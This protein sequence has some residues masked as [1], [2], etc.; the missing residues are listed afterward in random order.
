LSV[1]SGSTAAAAGCMR[2][3]PGCPASGSCPARVREHSLRSVS[4]RQATT[5]VI[6]SDR[7]SARRV[8]TSASSKRADSIRVSDPGSCGWQACPER[9]RAPGCSDSGPH[10][11][12][13]TC[14]DRDGWQGRKIADLCG[15]LQLTQIRGVRETA[16]LG[17]Y[18]DTSA[19]PN[20]DFL[21]IRH[22]NRAGRAPKALYKTIRVVCDPDL[23][24][25]G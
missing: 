18:C 15:P 10:P 4:S 2:M 17:I 6:R 20:A 1:P 23:E 22:N 14:D 8:D 5:P 24:R 13:N 12:R 7:S 3:A 16:M 9:G 21:Q 25:P 19:A 11:R